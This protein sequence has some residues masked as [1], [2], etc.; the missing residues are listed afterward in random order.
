MFIVYSKMK[1][2]TYQFKLIMKRK[3]VDTKMLK[4]EL[5]HTRYNNQLK[6]KRKIKTLTSRPLSVHAV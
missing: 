2:T 4:N 5:I 1:N 6:N 3:M